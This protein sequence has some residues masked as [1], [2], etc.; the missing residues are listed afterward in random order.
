MMIRSLLLFILTTGIGLP[1][2][3]QRNAAQ[4]T[5]S[6]AGAAQRSAA[7]SDS[8]ASPVFYLG[9]VEVTAPFWRD[10]LPL[11]TPD[12]LT[13]EQMQNTNSRDLSE[14]LN[15][16]PGLSRFSSGSRNEGQ[17]FVRGFD[18][19]QVPLLV[20]GVPVY[21]PYDGYVDLSRFLTY[22][23]SEI[24]VDK[25]DASLLY[26]P[27]ALGGAINL[28]TRKPA[29]PLDVRAQAGLMSGQGSVL[30]LNAGGQWGSWYTQL[31]L[32]RLQRETYPLSDEAVGGDLVPDNT[33]SNAY[34]EDIRL[35]AKLGYQ[36]KNGSEYALS[37]VNQQGEKGQPPYVGTDSLTRVRYWQWPQWDKQSLYFLSRTVLGSGYL[38]AR[39]YYDGFVNALFAYDDDTYTTQDTRR[40]F[41]SYYDADSYGASLEAGLTRQAQHQPKVAAHFKHDKH[42]EHDAGEPERMMRDQTFSLG[43]EDT[44]RLS[45][46]WQLQGGASLDYRDNVRAE[47]YDGESIYAF[48]DNDN[49]TYN[50]GVSSQLRLG[51]Y[52]LSASVA[53]KT[54]FPTL[55]DRYSFRLGQALPN[56]QLAPEQAYNTELGVTTEWSHIGVNV[57]GFYSALSDVI[58]RVDHVQEDLFQL[59]NT[60]RARFYGVEA[61][62][63]YPIQDWVSL[64]ANYTYLQR[65]NQDRPDLKF[66][67]TPTHQAM[68]LVDARPIERVQVFT[69]LELAD[70]RYSRSDG[71]SVD[72]YA[73]WNAKVKIDIFPQLALEGGVRNLTDTHYALE[74][75]YPEEGR[76]YF[77]NLVFHYQKMRP[78]K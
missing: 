49:L 71:L 46:G 76:N 12:R 55:K 66:T 47:G 38:K 52:A 14:A 19:R 59:Q 35:G 10:T 45:E 6:T 16:L 50:W 17:V 51:S 68:L 28:I 70:D 41:R 37:Y 2:F 4:R 74:E 29:G 53:R 26:G 32:S 69:S 7:Q 77:V 15:L 60:G 25:S 8:V 75:G 30:N 64:Q 24:R 73:V 56:P 54:R 62:L 61:S 34:R 72:G 31:D 11:P 5:V 39:F 9:E 23:L 20:D 65:E 78:W 1:L 18:L 67:G 48:A 33:R 36:T 43:V 27:N 58:Q 13:L 21:V 40:S 63:R 3:A 57:T 44:W 42:T 22:G